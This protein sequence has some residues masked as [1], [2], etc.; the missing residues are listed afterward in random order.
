MSHI[1]KQLQERDIN[2]H[3]K[4]GGVLAS[5]WKAF[6]ISLLVFIGIMIVLIPF[7]MS[8]D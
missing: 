1:A 2:Q 3:I 6:G 4:N 8:Y 7:A 5:N